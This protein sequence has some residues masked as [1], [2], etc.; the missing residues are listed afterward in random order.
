MRLSSSSA[1]M[2]RARSCGSLRSLNFMRVG[3]PHD[4]EKRLPRKQGGIGAFARLFFR[5]E[6]SKSALAAQNANA[7]P[8]ADHEKDWLGLKQGAT[9]D[10]TAVYHPQYRGGRAVARH[11]HAHAGFG[12]RLFGARTGIVQ[13]GRAGSGVARV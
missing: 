10:Y 7:R 2:A 3:K 6:F 4:A 5:C 12:A 11:S 9:P 1:E 13:K 8:V